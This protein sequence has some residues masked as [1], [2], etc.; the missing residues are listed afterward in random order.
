MTPRRTRKPS[1]AKLA[2]QNMAVKEEQGVECL[3]VRCACDVLA[4][5]KICQKSFDIFRVEMIRGLAP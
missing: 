3:I 5:G 1:L 2:A 4:H